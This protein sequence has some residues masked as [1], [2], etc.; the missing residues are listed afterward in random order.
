MRVRTC[1]E[2]PGEGDEMAMESIVWNLRKNEANESALLE[3]N[4]FVYNVICNFKLFY[5]YVVY[6][7]RRLRYAPFNQR[8]FEILRKVSFGKLL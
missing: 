3:T 1:R 6:G 2:W 4:L 8:Q 5:V 7:M